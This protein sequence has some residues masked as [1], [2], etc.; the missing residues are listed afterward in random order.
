MCN[1]FHAKFMNMN[2]SCFNCFSESPVSVS[3]KNQCIFFILQRT[4]ERP[5]GNPNLYPVMVFIHGGGWTMGASQQYP[6]QFIAERKVVVVTFNYRLNALGMQ[7]YFIV[8]EGIFHPQK[9]Q[10]CLS[11]LS[12]I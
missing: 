11:V 1:P 6:A 12:R 3:K 9:I 4:D 8:D 10:I 7:F 5:I 2:L